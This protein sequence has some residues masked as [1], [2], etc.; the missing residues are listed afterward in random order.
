M[1]DLLIREKLADLVTQFKCSRCVIVSQ[2]DNAVSSVEKDFHIT[3]GSGTTTAMAVKSF[4]VDDVGLES[5]SVVFTLFG[6]SQERDHL[7]GEQFI[8]PEARR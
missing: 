6:R 5:V 7:S 1:S 4:T 3:T 8:V 2:N